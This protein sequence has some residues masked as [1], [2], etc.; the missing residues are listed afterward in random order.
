M[1]FIPAN[2]FVTKPQFIRSSTSNDFDEPSSENAFTNNRLTD[3]CSNF[4]NASCIFVDFVSY[5]K[6]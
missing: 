1:T 3:A 6:K 2:S 4:C 5:K